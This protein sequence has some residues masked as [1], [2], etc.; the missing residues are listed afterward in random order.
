MEEEFRDRTKI[1]LLTQDDDPRIGLVVVISITTSEG[2]TNTGPDQDVKVI[3][4][5]FGEL[6]NYAVWEVQ[7]PHKEKIQ[8]A[9]QHAIINLP[10]KYKH[11]IVYYSGHGCSD[12]DGKAYIETQKKDDNSETKLY[13]ETD[14]ISMFKKERARLQNKYCMFFFDCCLDLPGS[15]G[16]I[17]QVSTVNQGLGDCLIAANPSVTTSNSSHGMSVF[18]PPDGFY[19]V[20]YSTTLR[21]KAYGNYIQGGSWTS[22]LCENITNY[23]LPISTILEITWWD[24]VKEG[25]NTGCIQAPHFISNIGPVFLRGNKRKNNQGVEYDHAEEFVKYFKHTPQQPPVQQPFVSL[26]QPPVQ[27]PIRFSPA[28]TITAT[29]CFSPA[30]TCTPI[31]CFCPATT[32]C[33]PTTTCTSTIRS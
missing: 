4:K 31:I 24:L 6:L 1:N 29:I 32:C 14:I 9:L 26:Q 30:T 17:N 16:T 15:G 25:S 23:D 5:T 11:I 22:K 2:P 3:K 19:L 13:I 10:H 33:S 18:L 12:Q 27:Q 28:T 21:S 20:A 7:N 8:Q